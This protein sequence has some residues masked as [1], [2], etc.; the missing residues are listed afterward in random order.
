MGNAIRSCARPAGS[1]AYWRVAAQVDVVLETAFAPVGGVPGQGFRLPAE[2]GVEVPVEAARFRRA[3]RDYPGAHP[4]ELSLRW[5]A[6]P[7]LW[8][9]GNVGRVKCATN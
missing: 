5:Q 4:P 1:I 9:P 7:D 8:L 6:Q 3:E 2:V